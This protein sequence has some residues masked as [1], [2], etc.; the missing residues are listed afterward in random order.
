[1]DRPTKKPPTLTDQIKAMRAKGK[2]LFFPAARINSVKAIASRIGTTSD[3]SRRYVTEQ[4]DSESEPK[5]AGVWVWR[6]K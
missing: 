6:L 5:I 3:P 2:P 1:M 4:G